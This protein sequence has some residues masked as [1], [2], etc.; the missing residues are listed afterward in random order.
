MFSV[1][2]QAT[3]T[4]YAD[5]IRSC[6]KDLCGTSITHISHSQ[7]ILKISINLFYATDTL[8]ESGAAINIMPVLGNM[9]T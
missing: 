9:I 3:Q 4:E 7:R 8:F 2:F 5:I 6:N 1:L